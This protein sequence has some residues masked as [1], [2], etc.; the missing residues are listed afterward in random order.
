MKILKQNKNT[1]YLSV[2]V[3]KFNYRSELLLESDV[4]NVGIQKQDK[5]VTLKPMNKETQNFFYD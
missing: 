3:I 4:V 1:D 5:N 2:D